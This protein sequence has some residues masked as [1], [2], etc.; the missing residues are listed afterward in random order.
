MGIQGTVTSFSIDILN[1]DAVKLLDP[2]F[3]DASQTWNSYPY[4]SNADAELHPDARVLYL[5]RHSVFSLV[6]IDGCLP[7][8]F[9]DDFENGD[10]ARWSKTVSQ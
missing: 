2:D 5:A 10:T 7:I 9:S 4:I 3:W 6:S 1:D 8:W